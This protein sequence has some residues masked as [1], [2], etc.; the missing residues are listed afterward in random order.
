MKSLKGIEKLTRLTYIK[1]GKKWI[2]LD[3]NYISSLEELAELTNLTYI[4]GNQNEITNLR[5]LEKLDKLNSIS[6]CMSINSF[7][8]K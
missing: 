5:G 6:L 8:L 2:D 1:F 4:S 7:R 3:D